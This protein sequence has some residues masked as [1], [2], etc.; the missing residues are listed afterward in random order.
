M[1]DNLNTWKAWLEQHQQA[2]KVVSAATVKASE[3]RHQMEMAEL[4]L[5]SLTHRESPHGLQISQPATPEQVQK[6][7]GA[8]TAKLERSAT[9]KH[10]PSRLELQKA[11]S[12]LQKARGRY[13]EAHATHVELSD[14]QSQ[15]EKALTA[16]VKDRPEATPQAL[17]A[18]TQAMD[19][20]QQHI[21]K[22]NVTITAMKD[23]KSIIADLE[24]QARRAA[25]EVDRLEA[26]ALMG[27]VDETA[28]GQATTTLAKARKAAEKAAEQAE[29]QASGRRGLERIRD[30]LQAE[31]T[32]LESLQ[33]GVGYEVGKAAIAKAERE[34]LEAIEVAGL[35]DRVAAINAARDEASFYAP[36][37]TGYNSA[38]IELRLS[39]FY[40]MDAPE[41][42]E[43]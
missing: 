35:Q 37:G 25:E 32:E 1:N 17:E 28:K 30:D 33:R 40:M 6:V 42:L 4:H 38:H 18:V 3:A 23:S 5:T 12:D 16:I 14:E 9:H 21:D 24:D 10:D 8:L 43:F 36:E 19:A 41:R 2:Q 31:L 34:L 26:S 29:K 27:E 15:A 22:I 20:H 39:T 11:L 13:D 7:T